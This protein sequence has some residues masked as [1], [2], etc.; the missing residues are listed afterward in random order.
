MPSPL[1]ILLA[2]I[3]SLAAWLAVPAG[4]HAYSVGISDQKVGMWADPRFE[5][6]GIEQVRLLMHWDLVLARDFSRYDKWMH[7]AAFRGA[8]VLLTINHHSRAKWRLPSD[9]QYRRVVRVLRKRYP[10]VKTMS[11]WNE[12]NHRTQPTFDRPRRAAQYYNIMRGECR[13]CRIVAAD[14]LDTKNMLGWLSVFKRHATRPR[15]WGLHN[16]GDTNHFR[17]LR[18][19]ATRQL[20]RAVKGEVWLTEA[21]GIVRYSPNFRGGRRGE[22]RAARAVKRTFQVARTSRRINRV[23]L[24][25]WDADRRFVAWDSGFVAANGRARPALDILRRQLN[26]QRRSLRQPLVR[27]LSRFPGR[28]LPLF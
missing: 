1:R 2:L 10:W 25:H 27:S 19:T 5:R 3:L 15:I 13:G 22:A 23:Y 11:A 21:G 12:A 8:D 4:A 17:P 14:V 6:L 16:Y 9:R 7:N 18:A 26:K 28:L 24:Y 20:L